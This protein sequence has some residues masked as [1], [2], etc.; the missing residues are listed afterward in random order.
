MGSLLSDRNTYEL[1]S[2]PPFRRIERELNARLLSLKKK[3]IDDSTYRKLHSTDGIPP[4]IRGSVKHHKKDNPLRPFDT[5]I[6]SAFYNTS[7]FLTD[8]FSPK[9]QQILGLQFLTVF[10]RNIRYY[11]S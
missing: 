3:K 11:N 9:S 4:D 10:P 2:T 8:I 7:K 5:C 1:V 6:T